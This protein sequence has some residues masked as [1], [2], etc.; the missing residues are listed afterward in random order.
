ME[1]HCHSGMSIIYDTVAKYSWSVGVRYH[2]IKD[3]IERVLEAWD[4]PVPEPA[5]E[6][7]CV[8]CGW[9]DFLDDNE[10]PGSKSMCKRK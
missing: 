6:E 2:R 3:V 7:D 1:T 4:E 8:D 9:W 5:V 10:E